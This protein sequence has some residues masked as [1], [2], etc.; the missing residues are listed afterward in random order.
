MN[1]NKK[2]KEVLILNT[3]LK[4]MCNNNG[5]YS[6]S[7]LKLCKEFRVN[8]KTLISTLEW[9]NIILHNN[10]TNKLR[11]QLIIAI[12]RGTKLSAEITLRMNS[13]DEWKD[14]T[15]DELQEYKEDLCIM[16]VRCNRTK[17]RTKTARFSGRI[18]NEA[19][20]KVSEEVWKKYGDKI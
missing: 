12:P 7:I 14:F 10:R 16:R 1:D 15:Y 6:D 20:Q 9:Y 2:Q 11:G 8:I 4:R 13:K 3:V 19:S 17:S 18:A 5:I